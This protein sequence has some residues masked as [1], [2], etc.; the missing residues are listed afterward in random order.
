LL[1][2]ARNDAFLLVRA[3]SRKSVIANE[4]KQPEQSGAQR[5]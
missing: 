1:R 5:S 2:S 4:V 3:N